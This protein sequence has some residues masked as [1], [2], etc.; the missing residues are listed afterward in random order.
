[1]KTEV[2]SWRLTPSRKARLERV[3]RSRNL[4]IA[5]AL[6][7]AVDEWLAK[8]PEELADEEQKRLHAIAARIIGSVTSGDRHGSTTVRQ[9]VRKRLAEKYGR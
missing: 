9:T 4:K 6:D 8:Y 1:M 3:A 2:Y 7:I 5:Q